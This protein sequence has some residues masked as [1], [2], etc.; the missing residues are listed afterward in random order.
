MSSARSVLPRT[1]HAFF[2]RFGG[3]LRPIQEAAAADVAAGRDALLVAPAAAGKTEAAAAPLLERLLPELTG[4][5]PGLL[6]VSPTRALAND[7]LRRL[8][9]PC[10]ALGVEVARRTGDHPSAMR[11]A[12]PPHVLITTPESLD[13]ILCRRPA[14]LRDVRAAVLDELH[15]L[16]ESG[17]GDQLAVLVERLRRVARRPLQTV[18][19]SATLSEPESVGRRFQRQPVLHRVGGER[20]IDVEFLDPGD[21]DAAGALGAAVR[22]AGLRKVLGYVDR[23]DGAEAAAALLAGRTPFGDAVF[24]HHGSLALPVRER[25][26]EEFLRRP[27]A[28]CVATSTLEVGIDVGDVDAVVLF[29]P[30]LSVASFLQRIGRG[31]RRTGRARV[32]VWAPSPGVRRWIE[33]LVDLARAGD[34]RADRVPFRPGVLAQQAI[35]LVFQNR[36]RWVSAGALAERLP[37][38]VRDRWTPGDLEAVLSGLVTGGWLAPAGRGRYGAGE[39]AWRAFERGRMHGVIEDSAGEAEVIDELTGATVGRVASASTPERMALGGRTWR[40][41]GEREGAVAVRGDAAAAGPPAFRVRPGPVVGRRL[42]EAFRDA[43]GLPPDALP[44]L[45]AAGGGWTV[46]HFL[47]TIAG[48]VIAAAVGAA[49]GRRVGRSRAFCFDWAGED[50]ADLR[51]PSAGAIEA[52]VEARA[53]RLAR[54]LGS[55]PWTAH[56]PRELTARFAREAID[57]ADLAARVA[58]WRVVHEAPPI[59]DGPGAFPWGSGAPSGDDGPPG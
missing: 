5:R 44:V 29:H 10:G 35:S 1:G 17:R 7:L 16:L 27:R 20:P 25:T 45:P 56:L 54:R 39:R 30:P 11:A 55:G 31:N 12:K 53:T 23:R 32:L 38:D 2:A 57:P 49:T 9:G 18:I 21:G 22:R 8:E 36:A 34:L 4:L 37:S 51:P 48:E 14:V 6:Y 58:R 59:H 24:V 26:E 41:V 43:L 50:P 42:C 15:L 3:R 13:S 47:G 19:L 40:V 33:M 52:A 28:L 46:Y